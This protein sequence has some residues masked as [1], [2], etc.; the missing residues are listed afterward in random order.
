M[1]K[2]ETNQGLSQ[3]TKTIVT[4]LLLIFV[5]PV[6]LILMIFWV[7]W[8]RWIKF[9]VAL[10]ATLL[11][12]LFF[13][14]LLLAGVN[15]SAQ[16]EKANKIKMYN[17]C[18]ESCEIVKDKENCLAGCGFYKSPTGKITITPVKKAIK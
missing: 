6:G 5:Y 12:L 18:V 11:F 2:T 15:P 14:G 1:K 7:K 10:P 3:D 8:A 16:I 17:E 13:G 4:V 9:L